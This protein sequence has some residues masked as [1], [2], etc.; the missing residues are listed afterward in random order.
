MRVAVT[1]V[2]QNP[3]MWRERRRAERFGEDAERYERAR[4]GY[5]D[6]IVDDLMATAPHE[7]AD[8]GCGTGKMGRLLA[9]R[10]CDVLGV[11]PDGRMAAVARSHGLRVEISPFETWDSREREFDL[12]VS[13]QSWHWIEPAAAIER[14]ALVLRVGAVLAVCWNRATYDDDLDRA[15]AEIYQRLAPSIATR[16]VV[17]GTVPD[18]KLGHH[19]PL[20]S[21][22]PMFSA[23]RRRVHRWRHEYT[24]AQF[25]DLL[26][27]HSDHRMLRAADRAR[28]L[29]EVERVIAGRG[30]RIAMHYRTTLLTAT[31]VA[32]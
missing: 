19:L 13:A 22:A 32:G 1:A 4:P 14:V 25:V 21:A 17:L 30:G 20:L 27:T 9:A 15:F 29:E 10:G 23:P 16:T 7:V 18:D 12:A 28:L 5:P 26:Q 31:R 11:E 6:A 24:G 8:I 2:C 3:R